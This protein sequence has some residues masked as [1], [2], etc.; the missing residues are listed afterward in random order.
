MSYNQNHADPQTVTNQWTTLNN[1]LTTQSS[2]QILQDT[3]DFLI[4]ERMFDLSEFLQCASLGKF[5]D[6]S[7]VLPWDTLLTAVPQFIAQLDTTGR[8]ALFLNVSE[9]KLNYLK[10][11][12][13]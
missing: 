10:T 4:D 5:W 12:G 8:L 1:N 7:W 9:D 3:V 6:S 11:Q 13:K 2:Q